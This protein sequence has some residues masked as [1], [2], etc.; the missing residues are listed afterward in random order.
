MPKA[1]TSSLLLLFTQG[2]LKTL[3]AACSCHTGGEN[4]NATVE[5]IGWILSA[6][7][8]TIMTSSI[9]IRMEWVHRKADLCEE[10]LKMLA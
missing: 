2:Q 9:K 6:I 8:C 7:M 4:I 5:R 10:R 1:S 3:S